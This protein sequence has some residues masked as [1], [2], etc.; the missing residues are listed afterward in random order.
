MWSKNCVLTHSTVV[1]ATQGNNPAIINPK[2]ATCQVTDT[3]LYV[4]LLLCRKKMTK[5]FYD[6]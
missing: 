5:N 2:N 6:N 4:P 3:K 1:L